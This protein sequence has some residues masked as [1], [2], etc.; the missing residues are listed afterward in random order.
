MSDERYSQIIKKINRA[1]DVAVYCHTNPDGDTLSSALALYSALKKQ[2]KKV[3][4]YCDMPV[5]SKYLCLHNSENI[6]FPSKGVHEL[7][8]SVDCAG[9]DRLG[10]CM[11]SYLSA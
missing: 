4:I 9:I 6:A 10:Q 2:G 7:A 11:K 1:D 3:N 8:I 5:P